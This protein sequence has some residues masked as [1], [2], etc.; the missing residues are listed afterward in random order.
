MKYPAEKYPKISVIT[1]AYNRAATIERAIQSCLAQNYPNLEYLVL[2]AASTD[3]TVDIINKYRDKIDYFRSHKD[4][5]PGQAINE[6]ITNATGEFI[7][8]L[9]S[10]DHYEDG[11]LLKLGEAIIEN[12]DVEMVNF[13]VQVF[14]VEDGIKKM[15]FVSKT[16]DLPLVKN[17]LNKLYTLARLY[18]KS[19]YDKYGLYIETYNNRPTTANDYE[20]IMRLSMHDI[21]SVTLDVVGYTCEAHEQSLSFNKAKYTKLKQS[22][23]KVFYLEHLF[24]KYAKDIEPSFH[25]LLWKEYKKAYPRRVVKNFVDKNY[26]LAFANLKNGIQK[27]GIGFLF[28]T[29]KFWASYSL[30]L[31]RFTKRIKQQLSST[32]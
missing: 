15:N 19:L 23:E 6:G 20:H 14:K 10:D 8:L 1:V 4:S 7:S 5:G 12:P 22:D 30:R 32:S 31:N 2:D 29:L 25:K 26:K 13:N 21:K 3:G 17:K 18:K 11:I 28:K 27:F 9:N 24:E 16:E